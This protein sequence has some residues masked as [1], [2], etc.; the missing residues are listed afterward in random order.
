MYADMISQAGI[1]VDAYAVRVQMGQPAPGRV[2]RDLAAISDMLDRYAELD[3]PLAVTAVGVPS[4]FVPAP[5][6]Q[7]RGRDAAPPAPPPD[8]G[9]W[10]APWSPEIQARWLTQALSVIAGKPFVHNVCWQDLYDSPVAD[11]PAGGVLTDSG[12]AKP[13]A[14]ALADLRK[15]I[16]GRVRERGAA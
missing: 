4:H 9:F 8:P 5:A 11:M 2:T 16:Q 15:S 1:A 6:P 14:V 3:K 7:A 12:V 13:A 10:R